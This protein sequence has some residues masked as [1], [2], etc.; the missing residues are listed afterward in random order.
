[1]TASARSD[2]LKFLRSSVI[3][4][5]GTQG[6]KPTKIAEVAKLLGGFSLDPHDQSAGARRFRKVFY[7]TV[8]GK[9]WATVDADG[10]V[11]EPANPDEELV[12]Q[13]PVIACPSFRLPGFNVFF[14]TQGASLKEQFEARQSDIPVNTAGE[15]T[16]RVYGIGTLTQSANLGDST[17]I[18]DARDG[19]LNP[20]QAGDLICFS[21][22]YW[23]AAQD[24]PL[25]TVVTGYVSGQN[26]ILTTVSATAVIYLGDA[27]TIQLAEPL[28]YD[29]RKKSFV[30]VGIKMDG[31]VTNHADAVVITRGS[32]NSSTGSYD[33]TAYPITVHPE[34]GIAQQWT[35]SFVSNFAFNLIGDTLG[36]V[37]GGNTSGDLIPINPKNNKP[38]FTFDNAGF[39]GTWQTGD[40]IRFYTFTQVIPFWLYI[41]VPANTSSVDG[42]GFDVVVFN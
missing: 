42:I 15:P 6:G 37:G 29:V 10:N 26:P 17:I 31:Y 19:R 12:F 34:G 32:G 24:T 23:T 22:S 21:N 16:G 8:A 4:T 27:A 30:S 38:Y 36:T 9:T 25:W 28:N 14:L 41:D 35:L 3:N 20:F 40:T 7:G 33:D 13:S 11:I 39:Q 2:D 1:M 18:V 5:L